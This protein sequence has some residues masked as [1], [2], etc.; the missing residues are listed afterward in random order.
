MNSGRCRQPGWPHGEALVHQ[1]VVDEGVLVAVGAQ[2]LGVVLG[3]VA[4]LEQEHAHARVGRQLAR[5][6][7]AGRAAAEDHVVEVEAVGHRGA[8]SSTG[9]VRQTPTL[10]R[11]AG[12]W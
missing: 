7:A 8:D 6:D 3:A 9:S 10:T 1:A 4:L 2:R 12:L 5:E 11:S